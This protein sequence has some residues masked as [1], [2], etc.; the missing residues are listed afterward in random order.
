VIIVYIRAVFK[1][2]TTLESWRV[3]GHTLIAAPVFS[4]KN[5]KLGLAS[6]FVKISEGLFG[7]A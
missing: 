4:G 5:E 6:S 1:L 2:S 7:E 3:F